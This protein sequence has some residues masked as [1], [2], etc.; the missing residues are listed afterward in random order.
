[1]E[2]MI[3]KQ[4]IKEAVPEPKAPEA[5]VEAVVLRVRAMEMGRQAQARLDTAPAQERGALAAMGLV[6]QL[7]QLGPLPQGAQPR[8]LARELE[9]S[10]AFLNALPGAE[11]SRRLSSG[12]LMRQVAENAAR[13][14]EPEAPA[15]TR[16]P[17][18]R[19]GPG[20]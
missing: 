8:D 13:P 7:A 14:Q 3:I 2:E 16:E 20:L 18:E 9:Q 12:E 4:K 5:L 1:M 10:P 19:Q 15:Q 6:G 17:A 11:L